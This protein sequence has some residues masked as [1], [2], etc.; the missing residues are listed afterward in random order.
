MR[1]GFLFSLIRKD[2]K[3][4]LDELARRP[5]VA[6]EM[7]DDRELSFTVD[8][9]GGRPPRRFDVVLARSLTH[10][11]NLYALRLYE[12]QGVPCINTS[13]VVATCGDKLMTSTALAEAGVPQPALRVAFTPESALAAIEEMGYPV[14][15]KPVVGS[16]GR[17]LAK[18]NDRDA[19]EALLEHKTTLGSY[20]HGIFYI[21]EYVEKRG[22]DIRA[23]V[24]GDECIA[25]IYRTSPHWITNTARGGVA[26][27]CPI[28]PDLAELTVRAARAVGGGVVALD[29]FETPGGPIVNEVN[30]TMEFK[31]SVAPTGVDIPGRIVDFVLSRASM[32]GEGRCQ[33]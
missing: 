19:A 14:V 2:E 28:T 3:L 8:G 17:L 24:V 32:L 23:F 21:Q 12:S 6:V 7:L 20:Q 1:V 13:A 18:V 4:L 29:V 27:N 31:N 33:G 11:R 5:G 22:R 16:W 10:S 26:T 15:L 30:D 9:N 25:A